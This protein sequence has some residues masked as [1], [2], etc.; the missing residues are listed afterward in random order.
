MNLLI[1][2]CLLFLCPRV[3]GSFR[4]GVQPPTGSSNLPDRLEVGSNRLGGQI[5]I[6]ILF[7]RV[8]GVDEEDSPFHRTGMRENTSSQMNVTS[9]AVQ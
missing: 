6:R 3:G 4:S 5:C 2:F 8:G 9:G 1:V 7:L